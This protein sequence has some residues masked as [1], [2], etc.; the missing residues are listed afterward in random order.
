MTVSFIAA[1]LQPYYTKLTS[2]NMTYEP[3]NE[4]NR[5]LDFFLLFFNKL[6][7]YVFTKMNLN[8]DDSSFG[9]K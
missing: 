7:S 9:V 8:L 3:E 6:T 2:A 4:N 5:P 1:K